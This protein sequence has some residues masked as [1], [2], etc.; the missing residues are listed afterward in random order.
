M[1]WVRGGVCGGGVRV[2]I[3]QFIEGEIGQLFGLLH[4]EFAFG[5]LGF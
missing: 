3:G 2:L 1:A 4:Y 5:L